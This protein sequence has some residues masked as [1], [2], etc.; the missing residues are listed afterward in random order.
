[1]NG[2]EVFV[3]PLVAL[4]IVYGIALWEKRQEDKEDD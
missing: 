3:L 4:A 2:L 1:M